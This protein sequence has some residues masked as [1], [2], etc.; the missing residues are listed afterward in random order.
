MTNPK[1]NHN[2]FSG[3][4]SS[5]QKGRIKKVEARAAIVNGTLIPDA[6]GIREMVTTLRADLASDSTLKSRFSEDPRRVMAERGFARDLQTEIIL[7]AAAAD[8]GFTCASTGSCCC[9]TL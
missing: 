1:S 2:L 6:D 3:S 8:C 5:D 4:S 9:E 7:E